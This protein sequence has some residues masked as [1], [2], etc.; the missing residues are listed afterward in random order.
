MGAM[1]WASLDRHGSTNQS[2]AYA[3]GCRVGRGGRISGTRGQSLVR[4]VQSEVQKGSSRERR[5]SHGQAI[6]KLPKGRSG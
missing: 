4:E 2:L 5:R 6:P 1:A 3:Q